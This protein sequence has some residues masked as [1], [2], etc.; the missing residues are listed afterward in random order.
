[1]TKRIGVILAG[2]AALAALIAAGPSQAQTKLSFLIDN[3]PDT[4]AAAEALV[5]AYEKKAPDVSIDIEQR[6]G[7]GEG[8]NIIKT[9]LAT[10]EMTDV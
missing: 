9:R 3:S 1:M 2:A 6:P 5:A 7:G 10:G 4:V 8:D